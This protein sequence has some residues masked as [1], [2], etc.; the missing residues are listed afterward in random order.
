MALNQIGSAAGEAADDTSQRSAPPADSPE[1]LLDAIR[2][3][4]R[5]ADPIGQLLAAWRLAPP[6]G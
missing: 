2:R 3:N 5:P 1:S 6:A 4:L